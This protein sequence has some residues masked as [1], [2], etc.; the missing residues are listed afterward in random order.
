MTKVT[1]TIEN[2]VIY[3]DMENGVYYT[4][5]DYEEKFADLESWEKVMRFMPCVKF[6]A[7]A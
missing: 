7:E 3:Y 6:H 5:K 4:K 2:I 1:S